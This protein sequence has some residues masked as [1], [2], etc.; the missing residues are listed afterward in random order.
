M[1]KLL[2]GQISIDQYLSVGMPAVL[3]AADAVVTFVSK[4]WSLLSSNP[5][6]VFL[7]ASGLIGVGL[8]KFVS[9]R[10]AGH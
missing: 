5:L 1:V 3:V 8:R 4:A 7:L 2:D 9:M 6:T 10:R